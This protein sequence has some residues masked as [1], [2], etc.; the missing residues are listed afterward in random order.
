MPQRLRAALRASARTTRW[1]PLRVY[2]R[3]LASDC[4]VPQ[5][6][7]S[8]RRCGSSGTSA[9]SRSSG[10][11]AT[12]SAPPAWTPT[13]TAARR[14]RVRA[15]CRRAVRLE[16]GRRTPRRWSCRCPAP[17]P[18][19]PTS[20]ASW[21]DAS[22]CCA[23]PHRRRLCAVLLPPGAAA[24]RHAPRGRAVHGAEPGLAIHDPRWQPA[25]PS[26]ARAELAFDAGTWRAGQRGGAGF[27]FDNELGRARAWTCRPCASTAA[28]SR[29]AE[30]LPFVEAGGYGEPLVERS[31]PCAG[32]QRT[33]PRRR[34]TCGATAAAGS[35]SAMASGSRWTRCR[36]PAT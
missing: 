35:S 27:A 12:R 18:R 34:A 3:A 20:P 33:P 22:R 17:T 19:A 32:S 15:R 10:S 8:T 6:E 14:A 11:R 30:F 29:W 31:G 7:R 28:C 26:D 25:R 1:R 13:P 5:R 36:P 4:A 23:M 24:R 16:P 9:G 2:E 21:H